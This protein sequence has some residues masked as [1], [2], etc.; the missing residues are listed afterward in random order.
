MVGEVRL[1]AHGSGGAAVGPVDWGAR[2]ATGGAVIDGV[3][4]LVVACG[5]L[6]TVESPDPQPVNVA[7]VYA[8]RARPV[9]RPKPQARQRTTRTVPLPRP[10]LRRARRRA[11][12]AHGPGGPP[13]LSS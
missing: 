7:A 6:A 10:L 11:A 5:V 8:T 3:A 1:T 9:S 12:D 13:G 4:L 2:L